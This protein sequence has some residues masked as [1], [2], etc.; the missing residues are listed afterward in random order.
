MRRHAGERV[1]SPNTPGVITSRCWPSS[2]RSEERR[3]PRHRRSCRATAS[4]PSRWSTTRSPQGLQ[5]ERAR[6]AARPTRVAR[7]PRRAG[8][9]GRRW[10]EGR[11]GRLRSVRVGDGA[12]RVA[13]ADFLDGVNASY[14]AFCPAGYQGVAG[15]GRGDDTLSE[16]TNVP[17]SRPAMSSTN[18]EPPPDGGSF[19]G[20]RITAI[21]VAGGVGA[22][23][24]PE[25]W[26]VCVPAPA[27]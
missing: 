26:V 11:Q 10:R 16:E 13:Q 2:L 23:I 7:S 5:E 8:R 20:W 15:G 6:E 3:T 17:A 4:A 12:T 21:N 25:V 14:N 24:R 9:G 18:T 22:G 1:E 19:T 27:P